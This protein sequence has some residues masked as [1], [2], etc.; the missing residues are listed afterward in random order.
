MSID[1]EI[2]PRHRLVRTRRDGIC[3]P[4]RVTLMIVDVVNGL[5]TCM[6]AIAT[7]PTPFSVGARLDFDNYYFRG[8]RHPL[9]IG[10]RQ[11]SFQLLGLGSLHMKRTY[12]RDQCEGDP[13]VEA[14]R[15]MRSE[16]SPG[17]SKRNCSIG[18]ACHAIRMA[19]D[20]PSVFVPVRYAHSFLAWLR[21]YPPVQTCHPIRSIQKS[22][23][24]Q[25]ILFG[26]IREHF[27]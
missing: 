24:L 20:I 12:P 15:G 18:S 19:C 4:L 16:P 11:R 6:R 9:V 25:H 2:A 13:L 14:C 3:T 5:R 21:A 10:T 26:A 22:R 7:H 23:T 17:L 27:D 1:V 8:A